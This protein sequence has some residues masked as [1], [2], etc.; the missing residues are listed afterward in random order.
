[1]GEG[2]L[3]RGYVVERSTEPAPIHRWCGCRGVRPI[4]GDRPDC[5]VALHEGRCR[6]R[7]RGAGCVL[8]TAEMRMQPN[9]LRLTDTYSI[10]TRGISR[11]RCLEDTSSLT[12]RQSFIWL[13]AGFSTYARR[14]GGPKSTSRPTSKGTY[15]GL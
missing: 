9:R 15:S 10:Q 7:H 8:L 12:M 1:M 13:A 2:G 6:T 14:G 3:L 11:R 4:L 5:R